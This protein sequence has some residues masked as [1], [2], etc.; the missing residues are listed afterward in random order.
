MVSVFPDKCLLAS[1]G[2]TVWKNVLA[3]DGR[4]LDES[5]KLYI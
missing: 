5:F 1:S 3:S 4:A 2:K